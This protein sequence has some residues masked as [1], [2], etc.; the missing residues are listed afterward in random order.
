MP[1]YQI[2]GKNGVIYRVN[3]PDGLTKQQVVADV[4]GKFPEAG[5]PPQPEN[6][7]ERSGVVG[8]A[9]AYLADIPLQAFEGLTGVGK[10]LTDVFGAGNVASNAL[11]DVSQY[12]HDLRSSESRGQEKIN[13]ARSEAAKG[14]GA[15]GEIAAAGQNFLSSPL[16][17]TANL[18]GSALPFI[19]AAVATGGAGVPLML[20][21]A[22]GAGAIKG[23]IY[24]AMY[25]ASREHGANEEQAT[26]AAT[27]AQEYGGEN[28]DQIALGTVL[29]AV[30]S[31]T[32]LPRQ[33][34]SAIGRRAAAKVAEAGVEREVVKRS[35][36]RGMVAG[37]AEEA[38]PEAIQEGQE[39][40]ASN[41][42]QKRAGYD[43][44]LMSGV[45]GRAAEAGIASLIP[46]AYGGHR[47]VR[48]G[49]AQD[50]KK[51][52]DALPPNATPEVKDAAVERFIQRGFSEE[53]ARTV[54]KRM[55]AQK[56]AL[57]RQE[58][59]LRQQ[60]EEERAARTA[61]AE[62]SP[63]PDIN[64]PGMPGAEQEFA[65]PP[66]DPEEQAAMQQ[67]YE[68]EAG[69]APA[70][71]AP[72]PVRTVF[73]PNEADALIRRIGVEPE[74]Q[75][76]VE[77]ATGLT[78]D[79]LYSI[80]D[81]GP[82]PR[83]SRGRRPKDT[84]TTDM[85]GALPMQEAPG[86]AAKREEFNAQRFTSSEEKAALQEQVLQEAQAN[87]ERA[88]ALQQREAEQRE[89]TLGDIEYALRAQAPENAVYKV[90]YDPT[91]TNAPYKLVAETRLGKKPEEVLKAKTLQ[92]FSDQ[93]Y[94]RM[95]EL[96]PYIPEAPAALE[97]LES[98][99][100][101]EQ[102][103]PTVA[104]RMVQSFV[105]EVDAAREAGQIDNNQRAQLL[106]RM[107]RPN[108]YR[109]VNGKQVAND[110]IAKLEKAAL[111]AASTARNASAEEKEAAEAARMEANQRLRAAVKNG[112]L[113]PARAALKTM[114]ET[115]QDEKL[116]AKQRIGNAAV[117]E[118]LGRAEGADTKAE[119]VEA[120]DA[121]IDLKEAKVQ[122]YRRGAAKPARGTPIEQVQALVDNIVSKWKS[123]NPVTVV[124]SVA[125]IKDARLRAAIERDGAT[126]ARGLVAPDGTVYLIADNIDSIEDVKAVLFH[127][128]LGHVGL[129]KLFRNNLD[130]VLTALYRGN[131]NLRAEVDKWR[132]A[133]SGAY[134]QDANPL[135]R[136]VEEVL[137]ER[138]E[139]GVLEPTI[140]QR[141][142]TVV[143]DFAR[144]LGFSLKISDGDVAAI[145]RAA[146]DMVVD[147]KQESTA[148]KGMRY[149]GATLVPKYARP[150]TSK[151]NAKKLKSA[152][153]ALSKG[154]Q[155]V[156]NTFSTAGLNDGMEE[157]ASAHDSSIYQKAVTEN[158]DAI[159]PKFME[160]MATAM[161]TSGLLNWAKSLYSPQFHTAL[162]AVDDYVHKMNSMK[163][164]IN[165]H[166]D[167]VARLIRN[168]VDKYGSAQLATAMFT[169]RINEVSPD[170]FATRDE[171]LT[172]N[173]VLVEIEKRIVANS[174]D[175]ALAKRTI[176]EIKELVA[177]GKGDLRPKLK[178][179][180]TT[181][182]D[183]TK[184]SAQVEQLTEMTRRIRDTY[185]A[186]EKLGEQKNGHKVYLQMR[187]FYK[188][189]FDAELALL[190]E[191]I[192]S[193]T[194]KEQATRIQDMR[195]K[196]MREISTP[197]DAKKSGD[198]FWDINSDLFAKDYFPLMREGKYWLR[199]SEDKAS[200]REEE[201]HTFESVRE[202]QRAQKAVAARL[203]VDPEK[204]SGVIKTGYDI[205]ELQ[206]QIK[207]EDAILQRVFDIVEKARSQTNSTGRTDMD[208][209]V[210]AIYETWLQTT[211][212][213]SVRRRLMRAKEIAG[214]SPNVELH[215]RQQATSYA[216][217]L[218]KLAYAGRIRG[219]VDIARDIA[220][221]KERPTTERAKMG[222]FVRELEKRAN[223][224]LKPDPQNA[225]MNLMNRAAYYYYLTSA[226][227][228]MF[229]MTS[230]P[231]RVVPRLWRDYGVAKGTAMWVKYMQVWDSLG[232]VKVNREHTTFGDRID[233]IMP[234]VNG[235]HF[236][237]SNADLQWA[238]RAG[239]ERGILDMVTDTLVQNER[240]VPKV[241]GTGVK[242]V[243]QD[244]GAVTG[245]MM[246][247][248]FTGTENITRQSAYYMTFELA[249]DKYQKQNPNATEEEAR[250]YALEQAV[251][252]VRDTLGDFSSFERPS[253]AKG[254]YTR[255]L[256]L[257]KMHPLLQTKFMVGAIRDMAVGTGAERAGAV[258]E[259]SGVMMMAGMFGG[260]M[261][262]PLYSAMTYAFMAAF[263]YDDDDDED[264]R[265]M[266][267]SDDPRTAYNPDIFFRSWM[268]DK[269]GA[270]EVGGMS[271]A[272]ILT[273]G[274]ISALTGTETAS[275]TT[276]DLKNMWFRDA[277]AGDSMEDTAVQTAIANI[278]GLSMVAQYLRALDSF[279]EGDTKGGLTKIAPAFAR[280]WVTAAY[281]ASEGIKNRRGDV[282]IPKGELTAADSF[283]DMLGLRSP[284]LGRIQ[285]YYITRA[286]N[287]TR[288]EGERKGIL[289][290]IERKAMAGEFK[291]QDDFRQFWEDNVVP[292][293]RTY[294]DPEFVISMKTVQESMKSRGKI[295][296]RTVEGVQ[297]DKKTAPKDI[298]AQRRFVQ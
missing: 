99:A 244:T 198:I 279:K 35:L 94:G 240:S 166:S 27:K 175:K 127:E 267:A 146:H 200:G 117:Q 125:D 85:F 83:Y 62:P 285:E 220:N 71:A 126:D 235:S 241:R 133:N 161:P 129:A 110:A 254:T 152:T 195:A 168:F 269:F 212:E 52:L 258:K 11:E 51:E 150:K 90:D 47:E 16:E 251:S 281:N 238:M 176:A 261:G 157:M 260:L 165:E 91:D 153:E 264:V 67:A 108:A 231:I 113:N 148:V 65:P 1:T 95:M 159:S 98:P 169:S 228:A 273:T 277:V 193:V 259:F 114:V 246:S 132:K 173:K 45:A 30:A 163:N 276:L 13:A 295:R 144:R 272:D 49:V 69:G 224:E 255:P 5:I 274:P 298:A 75:S 172:N 134:A 140:M 247:F 79:D 177:K 257:F 116:G 44:D 25:R 147:G 115:R 242:R 139:V 158:I 78:L 3:G 88:A 131:A 119:K 137:A 186:W 73:S 10:T 270:I 106:Q 196:L 180:T 187:E 124:K 185:D 135:A 292:F 245:K 174:N 7:L 101:V 21:A 164:R 33:I 256:F 61:G 181:A 232:R 120:R 6:A 291:T 266:M 154:A 210:G 109:M 68:Q 84:E 227:T 77:A 82:G 87:Q 42:A 63:E 72:T 201:F 128:G 205:A 253:L 162:A 233:A 149:I 57:A 213:R 218:S 184:V 96:T 46:G 229:N 211:P 263:G 37:A 15:L 216:N 123:T 92:D 197:D 194:D 112:L 151:P 271:L 24:D 222:I 188:D 215:F 60:Q 217:Q 230:I 32:G 28:L 192:N 234:N 74:L 23:D 262:M 76:E 225:A 250:N 143:R 293:N 145:L 280:S 102:E 252:V 290:S 12:A 275:R 204:N 22:S 178:A 20:G 183:N 248:L 189:M 160:G 136:A 141:L 93:V 54:V 243:V 190:D 155:R 288:I 2:T 29:G 268:N 191:R 142:A 297:F 26:A 58:E 39:Q 121:R 18:V 64:A 105:S 38:I 8:N 34:S 130:G 48:A 221:E 50:V 236:V 208:E 41:L 156:K 36:P 203:G 226:S 100:R 207:G 286:K 80:A 111:D 103:A 66:V 97:E 179:L 17:S 223:Q 296:A 53:E 107:N 118:R 4:L 40:Y 237:K 239:K 14:K 56:D 170:E 138:S 167:K 202:L 9:A 294:P 104:T 182:I 31:A 284:R 282:L 287:E 86:E 89:E 278:A 122:K 206:D 19:G 55:A 199:V 59:A 81:S 171:A 249:L 209:L 70:Q 43:V 265:A 283:R 289:N 214:F 219:A